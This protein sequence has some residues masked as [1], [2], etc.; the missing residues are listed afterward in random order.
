[1]LGE[2]RYF[3]F[4]FF[5]IFFF[6]LAIRHSLLNWDMVFN[7][8]ICL[9]T[10]HGKLFEFS[11]GS[12]GA[13]LQNSDVQSVTLPSVFQYLVAIRLRGKSHFWFLGGQNDLAGQ[14]PN[15][16]RCLTFG[17]QRYS[18]RPVV[19][20]LEKHLITITNS[21]HWIKNINHLEINQS[22]ARPL[23]HCWGRTILS[24]LQNPCLNS[25]LRKLGRAYWPGQ[26]MTNMKHLPGQ[27]PSHWP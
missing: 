22:P 8:Y 6:F 15:Y 25:L 11:M 17:A 21:L 27:L 23:V 1:M 14:E 9:G 13:R 5:F 26:M 16:P 19:I 12:F 3:L 10:S 18:W 4:V 20:T 7:V 2:G 24:Y